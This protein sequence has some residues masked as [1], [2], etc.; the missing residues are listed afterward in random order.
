M[1][2]SGTCTIISVNLGTRACAGLVHQEDHRA[3]CLPASTTRRVADGIGA[4]R[5]WT[6]LLRL[7]ERDRPKA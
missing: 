7:Y 4:R 6:V 5:E 1:T 2:K 3:L